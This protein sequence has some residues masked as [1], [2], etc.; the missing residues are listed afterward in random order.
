M[1][2]LLETAVSG[3]VM[4]AVGWTLVHFTWQGAVIAAG[5]GIALAVLSRST[6]NARYVACCAAL[7]LMVL[8]PP[9][10][11]VTVLWLQQTPTALPAA[12]MSIETSSSLIRDRLAAVLPQLTLVWLTGVVLFQIRLLLQWVR[13]QRLKRCGT[14]PAPAIW[15]GIVDELA[16]RLGIVPTVRLCEST[17]ARVPMLIGWLRPVI[18][19]PAGMV[20]GLTPAQLRAVLA[21]EL[22]HVRRHDYLVNLVQ[23]VMESVLFYHPAVWWL[24][25]RLRVEREYCCDDVAVSLGGDALCYAQALSWLDA[26]RDVD[27]QPALAST[28]GP[29]M[30]RIQRLLGVKVRPAGSRGAWITPLA[31]TLAMITAVSALALARPAEI[32]ERHPHPDHDLALVGDRDV[33]E[34]IDLVAI[35]ERI[36]AEETALFSLLREAGLDNHE[37][38]IVLEGLSPGRRVA[39]AIEHAMHEARFVKSK[40]HESRAYVQQEVAAGRMSEADAREHLELVKVKLEKHFAKMAEQRH[41]RMIVDDAVHDRMRRLHDTIRADLT[42]GLITEQQATARLQEAEQELHEWMRHRRNA[43]HEILAGFKREMQRVHEQVDA[44]LEAGLITEDEAADRLRQAAETLHF[45]AMK[46]VEAG[47]AEKLHAV[48]D[49]LKADVK[50]GLITEEEAWELFHQAKRQMDDGRR[51]RHEMGAAMEF[52]EANMRAIHDQV[53]A[54]LAAGRLTASEAEKR[55]Q[56]ARIAFHEQWMRGQQRRTN[57]RDGEGHEHPH[58][59][60]DHGDHPDHDGH[61]HDGDRGRDNDHD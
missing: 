57:A 14:L 35:L 41:N 16:R 60:H 10:T 50:A 37:L 6:P 32:R 11:F 59:G 33:I 21:H 25:S 47:G 38:L 58:G 51:M 4:T 3:P 5:L 55:L 54:D 23:S 15:Q 53:K 24:S 36:D 42:A 17:L 31:I 9:V 12:F 61:G 27:C 29:L 43:T 2:A 48:G 19:V 26:F 1:S 46:L 30:N 44:A 39:N 40:M 18:L 52:V 20:T 34:Q 28:G 8:A 45:K 13:A 22:A 56:M 49:Q 7:G